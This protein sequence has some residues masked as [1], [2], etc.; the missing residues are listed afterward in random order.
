MKEHRNASGMLTVDFDEI[1][2]DMYGRITKDIV[3]EFFSQ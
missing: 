3:A 2:M 1:E